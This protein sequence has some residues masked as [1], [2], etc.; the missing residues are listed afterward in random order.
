[1]ILLLNLLENFLKR[2][3]FKMFCNILFSYCQFKPQ[4]NS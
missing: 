4:S 2:S 1:M 3:V